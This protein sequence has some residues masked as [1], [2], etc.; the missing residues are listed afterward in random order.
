MH[1]TPEVKRQG[2][3]LLREIRRTSVLAPYVW[4]GVSRAIEVNSDRLAD[5]LTVN[6]RAMRLF[7]T[8]D[9]VYREA[10]LLG[11]HG[12]HAQARRQWDLA[13]ASHPEE[14]ERAQRVVQWR[15]DDGMEALLPLLEYA[16][17]RTTKHAQQ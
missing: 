15:V 4:F 5:K 1:A 3:D 13:A 7:P 8:D 11:L 2:D 16:K 10:M 14:E 9:M 12:D 6:T 17:S